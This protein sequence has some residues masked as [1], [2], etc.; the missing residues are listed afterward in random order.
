M[1]LPKFKLDL[2]GY[3]QI[4]FPEIPA[5]IHSF[6]L[7]KPIISAT[8]LELISPITDLV[9]FLKTYIYISNLLWPSAQMAPEC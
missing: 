9:S 3:L 4:E 7:T 8:N 1:N 5:Q 6:L 2:A